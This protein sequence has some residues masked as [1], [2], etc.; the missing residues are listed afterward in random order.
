MRFSG[1]FANTFSR[2]TCPK[3]VVVLTFLLI[4]ASSTLTASAAE[5]DTKDDVKKLIKEAAKLTRAGLMPE[6]EEK[7][8]KALAIDANRN[9]TK[10]ELAYVLVKQRR[11]GE[12]Y[13]ICYPIVLAEPRNARAR[14][15]LG[16]MLISAGQ[17]QDARRVLYSAI[18]L[19]RSEDLAWA[20]YGMLDFYENRLA[21]SYANLLQAV[22]LS[23]NEPDYLF[24]LAQVS[25][26]SERYKEA[27][28]AYSD[29]LSVSKSTDADRRARI[30]GLISFLKFLGGVG[31]LYVNGSNE[32]TSVKF[33]LVGNRPI[34]KLRI[35]DNEEPLRFVLDTG[36][37]I[38]VLSEDIATERK[39]KA[40]AKGGHARGIGG[41]G[42]FAI[43]Y[44]LLKKVRLGDVSI[45]NVP[46]YIRKFHTDGQSGGQKVDGYIG[47]ALISKFLTTIDYGNLTFS[48]TR[49]ESDRKEFTD[50]DGGSQP[51]RLT[52][53]GFLSGQ[54]EIQ[55][56][57]SKLNFIVDTGASVSVISDRVSR[58]EGVSLFSNDERLRVVGAAG[59][60]EDVPTFLLPRVTFGDHSRESIMA[61]A[62]DLDVIN[63]ASGFEQAGILGGNFLKNYK[64]TFD[65][66]NSK[67]TFVPIKVEKE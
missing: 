56:V 23:P 55:G 41:D 8:R 43:V 15:V 49:K 30:I 65:F 38:S 25:A 51:L 18:A 66:R 12:A 32:Q 19:D 35:N 31:N 11:L 29:F 1:K 26:R 45:K 20:G 58:T 5:T 7:L 6:A 44:G 3:W 53:S 17:F 16:A 37:G 64:L 39:I 46:V 36:S 14:S 2:A 13:E 62:L 63:E 24:A 4:S 57:D 40:V 22:Y 67:V 50:S 28:E 48:L 27:A 34:I 9:D 21:A 10:V 61:I 42:R 33:E 60:T 47:L 59:V 54:V 52:S